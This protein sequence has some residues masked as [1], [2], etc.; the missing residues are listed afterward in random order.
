MD[1][2][3]IILFWEKLL[4]CDNA[5]VRF[6]AN[7]NRNHVRMFLSKYKIPSHNFSV[8]ELKYRIWKDF[9]DDCVSH[10]KIVF[11]LTQC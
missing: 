5:S 10:C 11:R 7:F 8:N 2:K 6:L 1:D 4:V 9:V 3:R